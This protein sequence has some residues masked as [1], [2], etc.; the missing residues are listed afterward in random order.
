MNEEMHYLDV[1]NSPI[2]FILCAVVILVVAVQAILFIRKGLKRGRELGMSETTLKKAITNSVMLSIVPSLPIIVMML[3][4]SVP[5]GKYFPWLRL[6]IVGSAV[7]EGTAANVAA[8]SQG[9]ADISDPGMTPN[10]FVVVM[11]VM[12]IGIIW[13]IV[14]NI[15][16]M[17]QLDKFSQKAKQS[18]ST[19]VPVFSA[20]L[21][22]AMLIT[23]SMPYVANARNLES[24]VAFVT[25]GLTTI[26]CNYLA[27][28]FNKPLIND[29]SL[30]I[31]LIVGMA[32][33]IVYA[34]IV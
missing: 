34:Q 3:A 33:V 32:S 17:N 11:F 10:V 14:F 9:L 20:A 13:G 21:F 22:T 4:L 25:A 19:F 29:F 5:L 1:A 12:T 6:S 27:K 2:V 18:G 26:L 15:L 16:F 8:Q 23:L 30:P 7:Y 24:I 31:A 28:R